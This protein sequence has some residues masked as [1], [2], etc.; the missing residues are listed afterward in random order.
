MFI[1][2]NQELFKASRKRAYFKSIIVILPST[3]NM[4][5][6]QTHQTFIGGESYVNADIQ[7]DIA[8]PLYG[9]IPFTVRGNRCGEQGEFIHITPGK[10]FSP[11]IHFPQTYIREAFKVKKRDI[12]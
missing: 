4:L 3:W 10:H 5:H 6:T 9:N 11:S 1:E 2:T 8:N 7:V 12:S